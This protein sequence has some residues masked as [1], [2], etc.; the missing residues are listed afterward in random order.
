MNDDGVCTPVDGG[1][2]VTNDDIVS[3]SD[4]VSFDGGECMACRDLHGMSVDR[5]AQQQTRNARGVVGDDGT[6][7][8]CNVKH[9]ECLAATNSLT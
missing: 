1:D 2:V 6:C 9:G 8:A 3:C 4:G 7:V 5:T